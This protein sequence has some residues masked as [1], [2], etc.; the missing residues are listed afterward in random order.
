[1]WN[2]LLSVVVSVLSFG[3]V[4]DGQTDNTAAFQQAI[5]SCAEQGGGIVSVPEG[6]YLMVRCRCVPI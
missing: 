5:D 4:G 3:A 2:I 6:C 1:M